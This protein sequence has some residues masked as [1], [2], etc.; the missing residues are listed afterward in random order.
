MKIKKAQM[1]TNK[2]LIDKLHAYFLEQDPNLVAKLLA[3]IM[4]DIHRFNNLEVL[5]D[6]ES[7]SLIERSTRNSLQLIDFARNGPQGPLTL[8]NWI[9]DEKI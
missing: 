8:T 6:E 3:G 4:L 1:I 5:S 2:E 9:Y 7:D